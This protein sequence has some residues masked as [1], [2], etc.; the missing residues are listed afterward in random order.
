[1]NCNNCSWSITDESQFCHACGAP[2][3][4]QTSSA[5]TESNTPPHL[6]NN[7]NVNFSPFEQSEQN[8]QGN[9]NQE[10]PNNMYTQQGSWGQN[11]EFG[12]PN[13]MQQ[14]P[15]RQQF[16][17]TPAH[18]LSIIAFVLVGISW[19]VPL[20]VDLFFSVPAIILG[21]L[22]VVVAF[23]QR[24]KDKNKAQNDPS[25]PNFSPPTVRN[26]ALITAFIAL[27]AAVVST[28]I[29]IALIIVWT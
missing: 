17:T 20:V 4:N 26:D 28:I 24:V 12:A 21:V 29:F 7:A 25:N 1:M 9:F 11:Q 27:G 8:L 19:F 6:D 13:T 14:P 5:T 18:V 3:E 15:M 23:I 10:N 16:Q 22:A 2:V